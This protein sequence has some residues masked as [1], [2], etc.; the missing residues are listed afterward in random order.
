MECKGETIS[1][2]QM[3]TLAFVQINI[4]LKWYWEW[5]ICNISIHFSDLFMR[6]TSIKIQYPQS[7][8]LL[9]LHL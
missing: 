4:Y 2:G 8:L 5:Q 7:L 1:N 9:L 3:F 6:I